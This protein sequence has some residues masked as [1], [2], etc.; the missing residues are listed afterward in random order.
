M[1][2]YSLDGNP[3]PDSSVSFE[4]SDYNSNTYSFGFDYNL[5]KKSSI[6]FGYLYSQ[7]NDRSTKN[8]NEDGTSYIDGTISNVKAHLVSLAYR[9][10]F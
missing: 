5:N 6:G 7:K 10:A 2:G 9:R 4:S 3:I 8:T 1:L